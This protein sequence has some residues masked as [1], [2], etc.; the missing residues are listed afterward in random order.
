MCI[1]STIFAGYITNYKKTTKL[2]AEKSFSNNIIGY[3]N[4]AKSYCYENRV[5]A[6]L[7][8]DVLG[9]KLILSNG[10]KQ[11]SIFKFPNNYK[12]ISAVNLNGKGFIMIHSDGSVSSK[13]R[14]NYQ[15]NDNKKNKAITI[16]WGIGYVEF[17]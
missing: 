14:I 13:L 8:G 3:V 5:D 6:T 11:L 7:S 15:D 16:S 12:I 10:V 17:S 2:L 9:N 1:L 4:N